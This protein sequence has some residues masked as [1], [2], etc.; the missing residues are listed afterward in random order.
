VRDSPAL[1]V[2]QA[3]IAAGADVV[4]YDPH[5]R[6]TAVRKVPELQVAHS[7][8]QALVG[9]DIA[10]LV[11][12]WPEFVSLDPHVVGNLMNHKRMVDARNVLDASMWRE[13][14]FM[15]QSMGRP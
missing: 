10:V 1:D 14:G 6:D 2:A 8:D 5:A 11:T 15:F 13:A 12:E 4:G 7:V 9:A 3:L